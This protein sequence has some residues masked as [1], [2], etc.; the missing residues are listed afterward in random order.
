M[1]RYIQEHKEVRFPTLIQGWRMER[2]F[3]PVAIENSRIQER[4]RGMVFDRVISLSRP[5]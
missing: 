2:V 5:S 4:E 3:K 1:N